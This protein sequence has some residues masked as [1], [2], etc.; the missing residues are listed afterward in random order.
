MSQCFTSSQHLGYFFLQLLGTWTTTTW[1]ENLLNN[2][3]LLFRHFRC[4]LD[5]FSF[6][7]GKTAAVILR[8]EYACFTISEQFLVWKPYHQW[9]HLLVSY[10]MVANVFHVDNSDACHYDCRVGNTGCFMSDRKWYTAISWFLAIL[11]LFSSMNGG[12]PE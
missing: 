7:S 3:K 6:K 5:T 2:V 8:T 1:T 10:P 11:L 9:S 4:F 12:S